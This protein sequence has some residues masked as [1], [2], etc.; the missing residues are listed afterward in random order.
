MILEDL[1]I[2]WQPNTLEARVLT[3]LDEAWLGMW[4]STPRDSLTWPTYWSSREVV[5]MEDVSQALRV[6]LRIAVTLQL[7]HAHLVELHYTYNTQGSTKTQA[8]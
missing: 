5:E 8:S 2:Q 1:V 3:H 7:T 6:S 4:L